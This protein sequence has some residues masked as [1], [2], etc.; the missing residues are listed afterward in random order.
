MERLA[1]VF[2]NWEPAPYEEVCLSQAAIIRK[3]IN[4]GQPLTAE[5]KSYVTRHVNSNSY[6]KKAIPVG[7]WRFDFS[8]ILVRY[9]VRHYGNWHEYNATDEDSLREYLCDPVEELIQA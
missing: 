8:D 9:L 3:K 4:D 5:E 7:G 1:S 6:F 2:V